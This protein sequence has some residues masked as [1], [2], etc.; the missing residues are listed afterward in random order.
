MTKRATLAALL[1]ASLATLHAA[2][3]PPSA[4]PEKIDRRALVTRHNVVLTSA[5]ESQPLQ[6]GNG[7]FAFGVDVTGLQTLY[8]NTMSQ[9]GWHSSP[10]P[11]GQQ[12]EDFRFTDWDTH[13]RNVGYATSAKGQE[14]LYS[15]LRE[16]PHRINLGKISLLVD[17]KPVV[18]GDLTQVRQ[19]LDLW[20]GL[21]TS[22]YALA[23]MPIE[24]ETCCHPTRDLIAVR[25]SRP[26]SVAIAFPYGSP[27][28]NG[29]DWQ[30]AAA[31]QTKLTLAPGRAD[32]ARQL[33]ADSYAVSL[34]WTGNKTSGT[35]EEKQPH[36]FVLS[37]VQEFV[38]AFGLKPDS[39]PLPTFAEVRAASAEHWEKFWMSG[40]AVDLSARNQY[41]ANGFT[42]DETDIPLP[43]HFAVGL[44]AN[45]L[46]DHVPTEA[47][48]GIHK[49][50]WQIELAL[51][52]GYGMATVGYGEI[53]PDMDGCWKQGP[54]GLGPEPG[55]K[56]WGSLGAWAWALSRAVD[57]LE[58]NPKVD[59]KR[60]AVV[61]FSRLGKATLWAGAQDER[62][63]LVV[64]N[65]SGGG[66][67]AL[68]KRI[69]GETVADLTNRPA[70]WFCPNF[71]QYANN[72]PALPM[73]QH[74]LAALIAPRPL[75]ITSGTEDLWSD[76][77]GEFLAGLGADPVYRLLGTDGLAQKE[78]P[79]PEHLVNSRIGYFLRTGK[80]NV[81]LTDWMAILAFADRHL[82]K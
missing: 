25:F 7:E 75:L 74:E 68:S 32:F 3:T 58:T 67:I 42:T 34:S 27:G 26:V 21:I 19:E 63:V 40:G 81:T 18:A 73:D 8:G 77:K 4:S 59:P 78:F 79:A 9:W 47:G 6:I 80:H 49:S 64:S 37:S 54:R 20:S 15:W 55:L 12:P 10:L 60:I 39:R 2:D 24:V 43:K 69:F 28:D 35:L 46:P 13:G 22:R 57:Y 45:K 38:C 52:R 36:T 29:A 61:G 70:R 62:F 50:M 31:H 51:D 30:Q 23:G 82:Q 14:K 11:P 76:P 48:R 41:A 53:E 71:K 65:A 56:D 72:E 44:F 1:L 5:D 66:G 17:G 16:N 33:D